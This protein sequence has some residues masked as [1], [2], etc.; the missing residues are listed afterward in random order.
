MKEF[1]FINTVKETLNNASYIG[2]D[3]AYIEEKD[4]VVTQDTLIEDVHF[5]QATTSPYD[6]GIKS[7]VVNLSDIASSGGVAKFVT[8]SVS[9]PSYIEA[10]YIKEFYKGV[11]HICEKHGV[12]VIGGDFTGA[13]KISISV[14]AIG[15]M[16][17]LAPA[18]RNKA[19]VHDYIVTTG[20][21]GKSAAGLYLLENNIKGH[22]KFKKAHITPS[23]KLNEGRL[24]LESSKKTPAMMDTS[25]GLADALYKISNDS[26]VD[27]EIDYSSICHDKELEIVA[28]LAG[29]DIFDWIFFG[30]EDYELVASVDE[31]TYEKIKDYFIIIGRVAKESENPKIIVK[32]QGDT[33]LIDDKSLSQKSYDHYKG[34]D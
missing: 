18:T 34:A 8:I 33:F 19:K 6:L 30:G 2:D 14:T 32:K 9:V 28:N 22:D 23:P 12:V 24:L 16:D 1:L 25:D 26:R 5:R 31:E 29:V 21:H 10:D 7:I 27:I 11:N 20:V 15:Y 3:T 17:K 13:S 4:L